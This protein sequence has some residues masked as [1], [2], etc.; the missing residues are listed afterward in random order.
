[1]KFFPSKTE[2]FRV[3]LSEDE[4]SERLKKFIL[5]VDSSQEERES[6]KFLFKGSWNS[7]AFTVS[8]ILRINDNFTP[9]IN[10]YLQSSSSEGT[11]VKVVYG[12]FPPT[13]R[14]L[15]FWTVLT[16]L[17]T[18]FFVAVYQAWLYGAISG[19]F[20]LVNYVLSR[21]N[22]FGQVRKSRRMLNKMLLS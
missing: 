10:G 13:K 2:I 4:M 17:I 14:L 18:L 5:T 11:L 16:L 19:A 12:M 6:G 15:T 20:C 22:F 9:L 3:D 8:L 21:E 1:M 7:E